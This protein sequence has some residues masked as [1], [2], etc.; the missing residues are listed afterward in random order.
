MSKL[1]TEHD[2]ITVT[3]MME[4]REVGKREKSRKEREREV[5]KMGRENLKK[6]GQGEETNRW[7]EE[8]IHGSTSWDWIWIWPFFP[9]SFLLL[10]Y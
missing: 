7:K 3:G 5:G 9:V 10:Y 1:C 8:E 6:V 2:V 4:E